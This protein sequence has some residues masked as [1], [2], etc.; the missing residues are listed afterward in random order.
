M[1]AEEIEVVN[2]IPSA[3]SLELVVT[4]KA[5]GYLNTNIAELETLVEKRLEDYKPENYMGNADLAKKDR[6]ELN[7]ARET[8]KT[9]RISLIN[10]LMK[11]YSD[12]ED[13][14]KNL[15]K[16]IDQASKAL[17]EIVKNK[18][19]EEKEQKRHKIELMWLT[20]NFDLFPLEKI[21]NPK[22][23]NKTCKDSEILAEMDKRIERTYTDLKTIERFYKDDAETV[24]AH[25]LMTLDIVETTKF[26]DELQKQKEVAHKEVEERAER[27]HQT[28][29][30]K[31]KQEVWKEVEQAEQRAD[32]SS[33]VDEAMGIT[34][35]PS[36][37]QYVL[38]LKCTE[39][40]LIDL[41]V[42]L[43]NAEIEFGC[44][45]LTF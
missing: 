35:T 11:P 22:W 34:S 16:K 43:N 36:K 24:K 39:Q 12:F 42:S 30:M 29:I 10:E 8:I 9:A 3:T 7:K 25:Y 1:E 32:V 5:V 4:E 40:E 2:D 27:E 37:R 44:E 38:T 6:A 18:E 33:L 31:Q 14:C 45:E 15:E 26:A 23:L 13:R 20:K 21:F 19:G 17:D 41:K 28:Q